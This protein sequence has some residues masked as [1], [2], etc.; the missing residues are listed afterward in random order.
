MQLAAPSYVAAAAALAAGGMIAVTPA[1]TEPDFHPGAVQLAATG[2]DIALADPLQTLQLDELSSN[3][4]LVMQELGLNG[5]L[6][7]A[8]ESLA[9]SIA[10]A[11]PSATAIGGSGL[12]GAVDRLFD[13]NNLLVV[14]TSENL[15]DSL[16]GG[17]NFDPVAINSSL[18]ISAGNA[19]TG[20]G[21]YASPDAGA[22]VV[23]APF[24]SGQI[25]GV[26]GATGNSLAAY[27]EFIAFLNTQ[28]GLTLADFA[29][30]NV[31]V[32]GE[33]MIAFNNDLIADE[34]AFNVNLLDEEVAAEVAAFGSNNALNGIIDRLINVDNLEL[35]TAE[36]TLNS[37]IGATDPTI[38]PADLTQSL[39]TGVGSSPTD[40]PNVF[41]TGD[42][43]GL[44]GIF[45]QNAA[46]LADLAGLSS[47]QISDAFAPGVFDAT[48]FTT[49]ISDLFDVSAFNN[50]GADVTPIVTDLSAIFTS[51][52]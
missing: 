37:L 36:N 27:N 43:G 26:E 9:S 22:P 30:T 46:L 32:L 52:F 23:G 4:A 31:P 24:L 51:L 13:A 5:D 35:A 7:A 39:L 17:D 12:S 2:S 33:A 19:T 6:V 44:E 49:A 47:T 34:L 3:A 38:S 20:P 40:I 8:E 14:G 29:A 50:L 45:D 42:L 41:D 25:G 18:I 1:K 16:F 28:Y 48:A 15:Y 10:S 21:L 11:F